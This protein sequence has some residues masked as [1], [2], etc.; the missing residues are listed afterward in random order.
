MNGFI[1]VLKPPGMTSHDVI[2]FL[3]R[4]LGIKKIGHAGTLDPQAA[5]VLPICIGQATRLVEHL[6][7]K[8]KEY[9]CRMRLGVSSTTQDAWGSAIEYKD[10]THI[11]LTDIKNI[12]PLFRGEIR[13][14]VPMYSAVKMGGVPLYKLA[15]QGKTAEPIERKVIINKLRLLEFYTPELTL[16]VECSKGTYI[17]TLCHDIGQS[18][19]TGGIM[20]FLLRTRVGSF[21]LQDSLTLEEVARLKAAAIL[22]MQNSILGMDGIVL[23]DDDLKL[24]RQGQRINFKNN[25]ADQIKTVVSKDTTTENDRNLAILD[26]FGMIQA[27]AILITDANNTFSIKPKKV[28]NLE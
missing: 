11:T 6:N 8:D 1:N 23:T 9:L 10:P 24:L 2:Y 19:S 15:R 13:Q 7:I 21:D 14:T 4:E 27:L 26:H 18:L 16:L 25:Y 17:R 5:G 28:F 12:L 22:P 3:R 20:S